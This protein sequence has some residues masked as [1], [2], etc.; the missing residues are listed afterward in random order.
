VDVADRVD[1]LVAEKASQ[2]LAR[3]GEHRAAQIVCSPWT[4]IMMIGDSG[5]CSR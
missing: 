5:P 2:E 3:A 1:Q 4:L